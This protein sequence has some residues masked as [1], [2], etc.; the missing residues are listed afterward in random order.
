MTGILQPLH[1]CHTF[2]GC[3]VDSHGQ[4]LITVNIIII[5]GY[6]MAYLIIESQTVIQ[7]FLFKVFW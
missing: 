7:G 3:L 4:P 5:V 6:L 2:V 1:G